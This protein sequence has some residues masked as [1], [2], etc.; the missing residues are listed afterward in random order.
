MEFLDFQHDFI[1][2]NSV[3]NSPRTCFDSIKSSKYSTH[4][5]LTPHLNHQ[6]FVPLMNNLFHPPHRADYNHEQLTSYPPKT[7]NHILHSTHSYEHKTNTMC[8][9]TTTR[10]TACACRVPS[11]EPCPRCPSSGYQACIDFQREEEEQ[12]GICVGLGT[13]PAQCKVTFLESSQVS[14]EEMVG[15]ID[16]GDVFGLVRSG[17]E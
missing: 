9:E 11:L 13:C 2:P 7:P 12:K 8:T 4:E 10:F 16:W 14:R 3:G 1:V 15:G 6:T 5:P 17:G